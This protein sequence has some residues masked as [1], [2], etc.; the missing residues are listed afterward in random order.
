MCIKETLRL[1]PLTVMVS[2]ISVE[3]VVADGYTLPKGMY[4]IWIILI[5]KSVLSMDGKGII[6]KDCRLVV[7]YQ[8]TMNTEWPKVSTMSY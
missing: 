2:K 5:N 4:C 1:Y 3:D 8:L 7:L 6:T